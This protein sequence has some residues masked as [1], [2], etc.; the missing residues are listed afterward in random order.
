MATNVVTTVNREPVEDIKVVGTLYDRAHKS[1]YL[2]ATYF[3]GLALEGGQL[4][5]RP[6]LV[7]AIDSATGKYV[8]YSETGSYGVGSDAAVGLMDTL[9]NLSLGD[10]MIDPLVHGAVVEARCYVLGG[11]GIPAAVKTALS[12]INWV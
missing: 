9:E 3:D 7:V 5:V 11:T 6:G 4:L 8:P 10:V 12:D 2:D 1:R